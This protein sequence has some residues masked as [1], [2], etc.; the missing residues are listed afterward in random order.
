MNLSLNNLSPKKK[1]QVIILFWIVAFLLL[2]SNPLIGIVMILVG[3]YWM[4]KIKQASPL[5]SQDKPREKQTDTQNENAASE[6]QAPSKNHDDLRTNFDADFKELL[7]IYKANKP[8]WELDVQRLIKEKFPEARPNVCPYCSTTFDFTAKRARKCPDCDKKM[9][10]RQGYFLSE[11]QIEDFEKSSQKYFDRQ[12]AISDLERNLQHAQDD[13][14]QKDTVDMNRYLAEAYRAAA[15]FANTKDQGGYSFWDKAWRYY[16]TA[17]TEEMKQTD[18]GMLQW[19]KLPEMMFEMSQM[20]VDQSRYDSSVRKDK[21]LVNALS[22]M[23]SALA[24]SIRFGE[25]E[26]YFLTELFQEVKKIIDAQKY[27]AEKVVEI[28]DRV[29]GQYKL[30]GKQRK[31]YESN[32][33]NILNYEVIRS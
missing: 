33:R 14:L 26:P 22:C 19:S 7:R 31:D 32:I 18:R 12:G 23:F 11:G 5:Y 25:E 1:K 9:V 20:I 29:A 27:S 21:I 8:N 15:K 6:E 10:V 4:Y 2:L 28:A 16:N 17:R 3:S 24:E 13:K 30:T